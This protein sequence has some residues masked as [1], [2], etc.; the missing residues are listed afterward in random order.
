MLDLFGIMAS[1][2]DMPGAD[3]KRWRFVPPAKEVMSIG[4]IGYYSDYIVC[5]V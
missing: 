3:L 5:C 4:N 2:M 1:G